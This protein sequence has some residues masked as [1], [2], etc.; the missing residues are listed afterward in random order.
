MQIHSREARILMAMSQE[1]SRGRSHPWPLKIVNPKS[2]KISR[3][4]RAILNP[5]PMHFVFSLV[6]C[7]LRVSSA[8]SHPIRSE[9][10]LPRWTRAERWLHGSVLSVPHLGDTNSTPS[11]VS[12]W[13][14]VTL[15]NTLS[16][17]ANPNYHT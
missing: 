16:K 2:T 15:P 9:E 11:C 17:S 1:N 6:G 4:L 5:L 13:V 7:P 12:C 3:E 14:T 10:N 8:S